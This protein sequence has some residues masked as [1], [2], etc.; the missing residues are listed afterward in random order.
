MVSPS[1]L[2]ALLASQSTLS[3]FS[4]DGVPS[5]IDGFHTVP[6]GAMFG[7]VYAVVYVESEDCLIAHHRDGYWTPLGGGVDRLETWDTGLD[8]MLL[9]Q[10]GMRLKKYLPF[11]VLRPLD[12]ANSQPLRVVCI[13]EASEVDD[14]NSPNLDPAIETVLATSNLMAQELLRETHPHFAGI[15]AVAAALHTSQSSASPSN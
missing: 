14:G 7:H 5:S 1:D 13:A 6:R 12:K 8:R 15:Y 3:E 10:C 2:D 9:R 11:A 4:I